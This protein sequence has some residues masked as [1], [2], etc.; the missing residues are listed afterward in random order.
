MSR[1]GDERLIDAPWQDPRVLYLQHATDPVTWLGPE[2][3]WAPPEWLD[4]EQ[5]AGDVSPAMRWMPGITAVQLVVDIFMGESVP[6]RHGHNYGD[7]V[8][9]GWAGVT[10]DGGL[11]A[12][13]LGRVQAILE[14]YADPIDPAFE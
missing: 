5:R 4:A 10:D 14:G 3:I 6:A 9:T 2:L 13:A 1:E 12:A 8:L 11:D 7:L